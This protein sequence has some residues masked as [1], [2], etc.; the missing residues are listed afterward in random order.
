MLFRRLWSR[1]APC[2]AHRYAGFRIGRVVNPHTPGTTQPPAPTTD[3]TTPQ[4]RARD[5][6]NNR[7]IL[8]AAPPHP[9]R[10]TVLLLAPC[11]RRLACF[12]MAGVVAPGAEVLRFVRHRTRG[13]HGTAY[14][15]KPT[16]YMV[17]SCNR[18]T[19]TRRATWA[20]RRS[21]RRRLSTTSTA[22]TAS[23]AARASQPRLPSR[24]AP[25]SA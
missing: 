17:A 15:T 10:A 22:H 5:T 2:C 14:G 6:C 12:V 25:P 24:L 13:G 8:A 20:S 7:R 16:H 4:A 23:A 19:A 21:R 9:T 18:P 11:L 1:G 3:T